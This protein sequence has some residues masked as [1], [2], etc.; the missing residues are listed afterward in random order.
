MHPTRITAG[1]NRGNERP[2][3][4]MLRCFAGSSR[5]FTLEI[6]A[7]D[8]EQLNTAIV[9]AAHSLGDPDRVSAIRLAANAICA[10]LDI[11]PRP[12]EPAKLH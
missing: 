4:T 12:V 9:Q 2:L 11:E 10:E 8:A 3:E 5:P 7:E 1:I 6:E